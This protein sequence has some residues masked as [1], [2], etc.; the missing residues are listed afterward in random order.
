M[1][2]MHHLKVHESMWEAIVTGVK[3]A[4][5]RL[6]DRDFKTEHRLKVGEVGSLLG[7]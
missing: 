1:T 3:K 4:E 2:T 5:F 7:S 6:N